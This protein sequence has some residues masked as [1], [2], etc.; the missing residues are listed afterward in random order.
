[1]KQCT[2]DFCDDNVHA[3]GLCKYHYNQKAKGYEPSPRRTV[4]HG[5]YEFCT[6]EG[7]GREHKSKG[8]CGAHFAQQ[9][10]GKPL[11]PI[12]PMVKMGE[13]HTNKDGYRIIG[14]GGK[15][16]LEHR[17]VMEQH[18]GR[19]L[20]PEETVH[21][22]NGIRSDNR[23]ENLELWS[24]SHPKGQRVEDKIAWAKEILKLYGDIL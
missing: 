3:K 5:T 1:M 8:L 14:V 6:F 21:H 2:L 24:T 13:G 12:R 16:K 4:V 19:E 23:L 18:I 10:R 20:L 17:Y 7:C 15:V 9:K 11:S 22:I